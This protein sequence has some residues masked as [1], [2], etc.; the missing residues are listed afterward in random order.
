MLTS[1]K[2]LPLACEYVFYRPEYIAKERPHGI[3]F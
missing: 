1:L 3:E 2:T